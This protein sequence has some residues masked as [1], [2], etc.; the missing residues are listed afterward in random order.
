MVEFMK[1]AMDWVFEKEADAAEDCHEKSEAIE[2][3]I[4]ENKLVM[5]ES[6][7]SL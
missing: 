7:R 4:V 3:K 1:S 2:N 5:T 6:N